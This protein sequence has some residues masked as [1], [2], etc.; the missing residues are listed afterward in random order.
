MTLLHDNSGDLRKTNYQQCAALASN[1]LFH[2]TL[3]FDINC[4]C[5]LGNSG[6]IFSL[7]HGAK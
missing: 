5:T 2:F 4:H 7:V 3:Y 1:L 6:R